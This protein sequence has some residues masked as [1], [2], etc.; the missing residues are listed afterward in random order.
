MA[1]MNMAK[2]GAPRVVA[3]RSGNSAVMKPQSYLGGS[4]FQSY[5]SATKQCG[6]RY[7]K[8]LNAQVVPIASAAEC[9]RR[10]SDAGFEVEVQPDLAAAL[11]S[12]VPAA[13]APKPAGRG[14]VSAAV[15]EP[16]GYLGGNFAAYREALTGAKYDGKVNRASLPVAVEIVKKLVAAGF[17]VDVAPDL[18]ER[19][20]NLVSQVREDVS[21]GKARAE[22]LDAELKKKG[23]SLFGYQKDGVAWL[24][25]RHNAL[26]LDDMGLGKAQPV[27]EHVLTPDGWV[28]IGSLKV[29]DLVIGSTGTPVCVTGVYPQGMK[30]VFR[31]TM[32]DGASTRCCMQ[33]LWHVQT[34]LD[35]S[36]GGKHRVLSLEDMV[37]QGLKYGWSCDNC[38][39]W[40]VPIVDAIQFSEKSFSV[41][42]Y[43]L[44]ALLANGRLGNSVQHSGPQE[45]RDEMLPYIPESLS[46]THCASAG[47][48]THTIA[49][50]RAGLANPLIRAIKELGLQHTESH[51]RFVPPQ[52]LCGSVQQRIDLL[53]G[54][55]DNDGTVGKKSGQLEYNTTSEQLAHDVMDLIRSLGGS[56]WMSTRR[57]KF[58][59]KGEVKEGR[60]DHRVRMAL[61][62]C[63]FRMSWKKAFFKPRTKYPPAHGIASVEPVCE[64]ECVCIA[65]DASD[66]LYVTEDFILTHNTIQTMTALP[67]GAPV[68]VVCPAVVKGVWKN[69]AAKWR[70]DFKVTILSG[71]NSFRWPAPGEIV[72]TNYDVL[73]DDIGTPPP[74][75]IVVGDEIH[76]IKAGTKSKRGARFRA[77]SKA[78][79]ESG[80]RSYGLTGTPLLNR[81]PE[82]WN[83]LN[84]LGL[85]EEAFGS[86]KQFVDTFDGTPGE[87]GGFEWGTPRA[88]APQK[89][90]RVS[91]RRVKKDVLPDLPSKVFQDVP[92][93]I[94][95]KEKKAIDKMLRDAGM[96]VGKIVAA[97]EAASSGKHDLPAFTEISAARAALAAA[98]IPALLEMVEEYEEAAEPL[99][100]FSAHRAPIDVLGE[101]E[102]WATITGDT[103]P[104]KRTEIVDAFQA[105][106]LRGVALTIKAGGTG[107]TLTRASNSV[108]VDEDWTPGNN[109]QAADRICRI[110]QTRGCN[111]RRLVS[112]HVLDERVADLLARK[113]GIISASVDASNT[114]AAKSSELEIVD[115][116]A[117]ASEARRETE[118]ADRE[119]REREEAKE[120]LAGLG[121]EERER[122]EREREEE[123]KRRRSEERDERAEARARRLGG[124]YEAEP[125]RRPAKDAVEEWAAASVVMLANLDPDNAFFQNNVGFSKADGGAGHWLA[126]QLRAGQGLTSGAWKL[127]KQLAY[128]YQGQV[129]G[130]PS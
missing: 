88:D 25:G 79:R 127:A 118:L 10:L 107:I 73:S 80:G 109:E 87:W 20:K 40:F 17:V 123:R 85:A 103:S 97:I 41:H 4:L 70:P 86:W 67:A 57:T 24:S 19:L 120:R 51:Q 111:Y 11:A 106:N 96:D 108:F 59:Y 128:R 2:G 110:G 8:P 81:P 14:L 116:D 82:L 125:E 6:A 50:A 130:P 12:T 115:F 61:P 104:E 39:K 26:L 37:G 47:E 30:P 7:D 43:L 60:T 15:F 69:E 112:D 63:P 124:E 9:V 29:G 72:V 65:V 42:P 18:A 53:Q 31:V 98:K 3:I 46:Y 62:F 44:G 16:A 114:T 32:T 119:A 90:G 27:S 101:R 129:G 64:E 13:E 54:L 76:L 117:L 105:G 94:S 84:S 34:P 49:S 38:T 126:Q 121:R 48:W 28:E 35:R 66:H 21:A 33:H 71:R 1:N 36:R 83:I 52:Y 122:V 23:L 58:T 45:Q 92:V 93:E 55:M 22:A 68:V 5:I 77:L 56:A 102:G 99:V 95:A 91:L 100:V 113:R 74:E 89:L 75:T 78:A